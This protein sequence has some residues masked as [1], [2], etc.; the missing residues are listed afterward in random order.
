MLRLGCGLAI[1]LLALP[2]TAWA[3]TEDEDFSPEMEI[4]L[5]SFDDQT[6]DTGWI[7]A[8]SPVQMRFFL[9]AGN[10]IFVA[11]P[12]D[13]VYDWDAEAIH[14]EGHP[15]TG[16]FEY[17]VGVLI[18]SKVRFDV[19]GQ[20]WESDL[21][22][23]YDWAITA[24]DEFT[25]FLL[26]GNPD[27]P[28]EVHDETGFINV[29]SVPI[30]P[31]LIVAE[32]TL[33]IDLKAV[34]DA[35]LAGARIEV[36]AT[37]PEGGEATVTVEGAAE[38]LD[39]GEEIVPFE[40]QGTLVCDLVTMPDVVIYPHLVITILFQDF[41]IGGIEIPVDLPTV[42][43]ELVFDPIPMEFHDR[44]EPEEPDTDTGESDDGNDDAGEGDT[45]ETGDGAGGASEDAGCGCASTGSGPG[46]WALLALVALRRRRGAYSGQSS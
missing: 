23:P 39:P 2:S 45:G 17:D 20:V 11:M 12:G 6:F 27:R 9:H 13:A 21:L 4:E 10:T 7:P 5:A 46:A 16:L 37:N 1:G 22:G 32:G 25:P 14:F 26:E 44:P 31:D 30:T 24:D 36:E 40:A 43:E 34:V 29:A 18:E 42:D 8:N 38:S 3:G 33:D 35:S 41:D 19:Q 28:S 15:D